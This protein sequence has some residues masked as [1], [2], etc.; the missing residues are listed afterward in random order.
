MARCKTCIR[1]R[2]HSGPCQQADRDRLLADETNAMADTV[3]DITYWVECSVKEAMVAGNSR[4]IRDMHERLHKAYHA[5]VVGNDEGAL[6][7]PVCGWRKQ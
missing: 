3:A 1:D 4:G 7:C 5:L 6:E 2:D